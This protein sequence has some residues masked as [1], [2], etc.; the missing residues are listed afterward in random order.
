MNGVDGV[1]GL[2]RPALRSSVIFVERKLGSSRA[3]ARFFDRIS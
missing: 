1:V 2:M 3:D